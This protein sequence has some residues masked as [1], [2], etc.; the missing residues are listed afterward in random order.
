MMFEDKTFCA[1]T[2]SLDSSR[3]FLFPEYQFMALINRFLEAKNSTG[4]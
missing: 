2:F 4:K 1:W 3:S